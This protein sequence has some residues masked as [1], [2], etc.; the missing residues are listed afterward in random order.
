MHLNQFPNTQKV[1]GRGETVISRANT[2]VPPTCR[3]VNP[4][5]CDAAI[6]SHL[7]VNAVQSLQEHDSSVEVSAEQEK[8]SKQRSE[9]IKKKLHV[10]VSGGDV[11]ALSGLVEHNL[12]QPT[13]TKIPACAF[14]KSDVKLLH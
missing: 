8:P 12:N 7:R 10:T 13:S 14:R 1:Q 11:I 9:A 2:A 6:P 5:A 4:F 3:A